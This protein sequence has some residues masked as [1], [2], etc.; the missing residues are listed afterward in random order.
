[1]CNEWRV[2]ILGVSRTAR[3]QFALVLA[4]WSPAPDEP[5]IPCREISLLQG[6]LCWTRQQRRSMCILCAVKSHGGYH[7]SLC[8]Y[9]QYST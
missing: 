2:R 4:T 8:D 1:M 7:M 5:T 3:E 9:P 6:L